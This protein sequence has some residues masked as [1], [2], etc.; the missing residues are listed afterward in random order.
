MFTVISIYD[1][2]LR[3]MTSAHRLLSSIQ[4]VKKLRLQR[5][6]D[7]RGGKNKH[8]F[9]YLTKLWVMHRFAVRWSYG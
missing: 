4:G 1:L 9:F 3:S 8:V 7:D 2:K 6:S 5:F